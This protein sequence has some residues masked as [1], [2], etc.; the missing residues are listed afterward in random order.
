MAFDISDGWK[1]RQ[2]EVWTRTHPN[3]SAVITRVN[4]GNNS[5][6]CVN[7]PDCGRFFINIA[8]YHHATFWDVKKKS[9]YILVVKLCPTDTIF[10]YKSTVCLPVCSVRLGIAEQEVQV[11]ASF[12][13]AHI[14]CCKESVW[15]CGGTVCTLG[16][17]QGAQ[18]SQLGWLKPRLQLH[19][20]GLNGCNLGCQICSAVD[21]L[22]AIAIKICWQSSYW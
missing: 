1:Q 16:I 22:L 13:N 14:S 10:T 17:F 19:D 15:S 11:G 4:A 18:D 5:D 8:V 2:P 12:A 9:L 6:H 7:P 20:G 21:H 3:N